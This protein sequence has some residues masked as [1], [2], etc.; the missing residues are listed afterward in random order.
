MEL[1][2][3]TIQ[4]VSVKV[5]AK[6]LNKQASL[7]QAIAEEAKN[8][9][10]NPEQV[11]R[12]IEA[13]NS[14]AYL[15]QLQSS[16]DRTFEFPV[17]D[18]KGVMS[19]LTL[20]EP[21]N[22]G[23]KPTVTTVEKQAEQKANDFDLCEQEKIAML[24]K[25]L[26][27]SQQ[28]LEKIAHDKAIVAQNL[29]TKAASIKTETNLLEKVAYVVEESD[30]DRMLNLVG[31]EKTACKRVLVTDSELTQVK[32]VYN[33]IKQA[34]E[35]L[36]HEKEVKAFI[37]KA[38]DILEKKAFFQLAGKALGSGLRAVGNS[39]SNLTKAT[40]GISHAVSNAKKTN[41]KANRF[42]VIK[43]YNRDAFLKG[44]PYASK[45]HGFTPTLAN[46]VSGG[47]ALSVGFAP[48]SDHKTNVWD[49]LHPKIK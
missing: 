32:E 13:S 39:V 41:P 3:D 8:L 11:K 10:L 35:I 26:F 28:S 47:V 17:A 22:Q 15:R 33:L 5:V 7:N 1:T 37:E 6:F 20:P 21:E 38:T 30:F 14:I 23:T 49:T 16:E 12:I 18:Y 40:T 24:A 2:S 9:N 46:K 42:T 27:K 36:A 25:E 34:D 29:L 45:V 44:K 31:L 4:N 48:L 43:D 19:S